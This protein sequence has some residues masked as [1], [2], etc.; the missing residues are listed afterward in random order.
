[1]HLAT[2]ETGAKHELL[3]NKLATAMTPQ[4]LP[5]PPSCLC[6]IAQGGQG[7]YWGVIAVASLL[8]K[9][10]CLAPALGVAKFIIVTEIV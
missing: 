4:Y 6:H 10:S 8:N 2:P 5:W 9:T 3:F 7:K 1:M